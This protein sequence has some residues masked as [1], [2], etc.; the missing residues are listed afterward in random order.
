MSSAWK[1]H[2]STMRIKNEWSASCK[3][4]VIAGVRK[5]SRKADLPRSTERSEGDP[6]MQGVWACS[7][8]PYTKSLLSWEE[9]ENSHPW[10]SIKCNGKGKPRISC[11]FLLNC[12]HGT[13]HFSDISGHQMCVL[14]HVK[15]FSETPAGCPIIQFNSYTIC[16]EILHPYTPEIQS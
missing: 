14:P 4:P 10:L 11:V 7:L 12:S 13:L 6:Y 8:V 3:M 15:Q 5:K 1:N 2:F 9:D 16:L